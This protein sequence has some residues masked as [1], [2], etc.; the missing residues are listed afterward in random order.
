MATTDPATAPALPPGAILVPDFIDKKEAAALLGLRAAAFWDTGLAR[1]VQHY[2]YEYDYSGRVRPKKTTPIPDELKKLTNALVEQ[3]LFGI[4][5]DQIIVN[6]YQPGQGIS[7]HTDHNAYFR[8][9]IATLS[10]GHAYQMDFTHAK[11]FPI[12]V[13]LPIGSLLVLKGPAR[14][15]WKHSIAARK[16]DPG[17]TGKRIPR[18]TRV[19]IT[20][21]TVV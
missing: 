19:S 8:D 5:P 12:S 17:P 15:E 10:L 21:R 13:T 4:A 20:F 7:A 9:T 11:H 3:K 1:R 2:G 16:T 18:G 14:Y 6:E